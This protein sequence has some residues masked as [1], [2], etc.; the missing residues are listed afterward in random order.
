MT[1]QFDLSKMSRSLSVGSVTEQMP[2]GGYFWSIASLTGAFLREAERR[3]LPRDPSWT[4]LGVQFTGK[5]PMLWYPT[6][7]NYPN[8]KQVIINLSAVAATDLNEAIFELA[9]EV[10]HLLSPTG[11]RRAP[12]LEEGL[13]AI[14][15]RDM[16]RACNLNIFVNHPSYLAAEADVRSLLAIDP[17]AIRKLRSARPSFVDFDPEFLLA[18]IPATPADL[19]QRLCKRYV[20]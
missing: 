8:I 7:P 17:E 1:C 6:N 5:R 14:F 18:V 9:V 15:C 10:V 4:F 19:A 3:Y 12:N 16:M 2:E 11:D 13:T 20:D